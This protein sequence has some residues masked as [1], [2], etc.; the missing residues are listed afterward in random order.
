MGASGSSR[1]AVARPRISN[2]WIFDDGEGRR[3]LIDTGHRVERAVLGR[4]LRAAGIRRGELTAVLLTHRHSDH[5][6]NAAW[7]RDELRCPV[8]CHSADARTLSGESPAARLGGRGAPHVHEALCRFEDRFPARSPVDEVYDEGTWRWG[9]EV[10]PVSG[11]TAGS[12]LLFHAATGTLFTGDAVL[13]GAPVQRFHARLSLAI[14]AYSEDVSACH[15][16]V[17]AFIAERRPI[18]ALCAG[19]GPLLRRN[20][21]DLLANLAAQS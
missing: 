2:S 5:A 9:F 7:V 10:I 21:V 16:A 14:P 8:V 3:F 19:H 17:R 11:H 1:V 6:G 20:V 18:S 13:S 15:R 12:S 4:S